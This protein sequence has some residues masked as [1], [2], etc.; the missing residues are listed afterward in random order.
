M[1]IYLHNSALR[2]LQKKLRD[3]RESIADWKERF[4]RQDTFHGIFS[5]F[6]II[7]YIIYQ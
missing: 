3:K 7:W 5:W 2:Q 4:R 1:P 6:G